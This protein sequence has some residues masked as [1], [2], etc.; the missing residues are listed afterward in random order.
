MI[1]S[2][3][4][5]PSSFLTFSFFLFST[6]P[7]AGDI[8]KLVLPEGMQVLQFGKCEKLSGKALKR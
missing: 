2:Q 5:S 6:F 8:G 7:P 1:S 3:F 4:L